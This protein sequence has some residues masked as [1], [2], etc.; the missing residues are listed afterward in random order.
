[1]P[2]RDGIWDFILGC[3]CWQWWIFVENLLLFRMRTDYTQRKLE[4]S[5]CAGRVLERLFPKVVGKA[6]RVLRKRAGNLSP[7]TG[8]H[9]F[10]RLVKMNCRQFPD[11]FAERRS[12][13]QLNE[14]KRW[15][16]DMLLQMAWSQYSAD[17]GLSVQSDY[18]PAGPRCDAPFLFRSYYQL[19]RL[20]K[21]NTGWLYN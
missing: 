20:Q 21:N 12:L 16:T 4:K 8:Q 6:G 2:Q 19:S 7:H 9:I 10:A 1:M 14:R 5:G 18:E 15:D 17:K 13:L 3:F 11:G